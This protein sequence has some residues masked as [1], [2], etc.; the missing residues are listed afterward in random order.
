MPTPEER[1]PLIPGTLN[2]L[3]LK[4]LSSGPR[5][6]LLTADWGRNDTGHAPGSTVSRARARRASR[7]RSPA[8]SGRP[9][10]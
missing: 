5:K 6:G 1:D 9:R 3:I 7:P 10:L 4:A 8:G 2:A